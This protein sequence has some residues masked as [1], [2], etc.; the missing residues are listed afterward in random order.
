MKVVVQHNW[1]TGLGD[2]YCAATQYLNMIKPIKEM[3]YET[4]LVFAYNSGNG[5]NKFIGLN[6]FDSIFDIDSFKVFDTISVENY[7]T[8]N[9]DYK[10]TKYHYTPY[11]PTAPGQHWYDVYFD[12]IPDIFSHR[13][14][15]PSGILDGSSKPIVYPKFND[16]VYKR[17]NKFIKDIGNDC[18]YIQIRYFDYGSLD[19]KFE[20]DLNTIYNK[21]KESQK[22]YHIGSNN[23]EALD[24]LSVLDNVYTYKFKNLD[25]FTNDHSYYF[26]NKNISNDMLL[27]RLYD[28]LAEMV[29]IA[30]C[31]TIYGYTS[32]GWI[33][34]FLFYGMTHND[35]NK[36]KFVNFNHLTL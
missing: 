10:D 35:P 18:D 19:E 4:E 12:E 31:N 7:S 17:S 30:K 34:N 2:L 20:N 27:D 22:K 28:N 3:G 8:N 5:G 16:E 36:L 11:G 23:A 9:V 25:L 13:H 21:L 15:T 24:R 1:T 29:A 6:E 33:S 26:Y 32:F 14:Y